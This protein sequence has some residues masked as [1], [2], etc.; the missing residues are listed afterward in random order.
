[1]RIQRLDHLVLT[2]TDPDRTV[3][4]YHHGL[5]MRLEVFDDGRRA[6]AFGEQKINLHPVGHE[7]DPKAACP[8][9][10]SGDLCLVADRPA[11][12]IH[13]HLRRE[14]IPVELG[15]VRRTGALGP[16][17]SLYVR[18]PDHNLIEISTYESPRPAH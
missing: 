4:F 12:E 16:I 1:M 14:G 11:E 5:G 13:E 18:D 2:V 6:L 9:P 15:P 17:T 8:T 10:G 7:I 3:D